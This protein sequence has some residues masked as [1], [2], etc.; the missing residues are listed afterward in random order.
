MDNTCSVLAANVGEVEVSGHHIPS[1]RNKRPSLAQSRVVAHPKDD[2]W[3]MPVG[4]LSST[5][6]EVPSGSKMA[7]VG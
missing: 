1:Y 7:L 6:E 2:P 5:N 3:K 4:S